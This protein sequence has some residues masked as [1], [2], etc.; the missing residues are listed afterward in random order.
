VTTTS[1]FDVTFHGVRG[2]TPCHG[3]EI[4][5]Y[6]GN[7]SCVSIDIPDHAPILFDLGTG[8]RYF[9]Q[10]W[11]TDVPFEAT[12]MVSHLHWDHIQGL[13][14]FPP[15]LRPDSRMH[16]IAPCQSSGQTVGEV[17]METIRPPLFPVDLA[18]LPGEFSCQGVQDETFMIGDDVEVMS[19]FIP[20]VGNTCGYRLTWN[21]LSVAYLSDHQMPEDGCFRATDGARELCRDA[22]LV[23]HDAQYT[24]D[25][26]TQK[27]DWGHCTV[28]YAVWLAAEVGAKQIALFHHDPNHDDDTLDLIGKLAAR[29]GSSLGVG[30]VTAREGLTLRV[31]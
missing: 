8:V 10:A 6:G 11:P 31:G 3:P 26:F 2:S 24:W 9:G 16:I 23:I 17:L 12:C 19:R 20:H 30:V 21:G 13:P 18:V 22:D 25:E 27:R 28:E 5:R 7:T 1:G 14:F 15:V 29:C 4:I